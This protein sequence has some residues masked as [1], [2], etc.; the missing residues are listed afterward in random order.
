MEK[1]KLILHLDINN[2]V[3]MKD[4]A[5]NYGLEFNVKLI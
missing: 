3:V 5:Q 1:P 4:S 2:T